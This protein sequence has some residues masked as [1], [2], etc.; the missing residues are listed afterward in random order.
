MGKTYDFGGWATKNDLKCADGRVIRRNAFKAQDGKTVPLVWRHDHLDLNNIIGHA[1]LENTDDGV[2]MYGAFNDSDLGKQAKLRVEHGDITGLS[3]WANNLVQNGPDVVHGDIKEVSLVIAPA[4]PGAYITFP[5][6]AHG[7]ESTTDA[8]IFTGEEIEVGPFISHEDD[9][10]DDEDG[11]E[12]DEKTVGDVLDTLNEE[13]MDAVVIAIGKA[14]EAATG[15]KI[16]TEDG[17]KEMK[18]NAFEDSA[19]QRTSN[20]LSH[21]DMASI[22][23]DAKRIGSLKAAVQQSMEN[24]VLSHAF[25]ENGRPYLLNDDGT[26]Q[27]YGVTD[28]DWLFP[29]YRNINNP[30]KFMP[31]DTGWVDVVMNGVHRN[32]FS[33]IK[34]QF[35]DIS[36]DEARAYGYVK[37]DKKDMEVFSLLRRTVD[38]QTI[39]KMQQLDRDDI[40]DITDFDIVAWIKQEMRMKLNEEIARAILIGDGRLTTDRHHIKEQ[41]LMPVLAD[42]ELFTIRRV[43]QRASGDTVAKMAKKFIDNNI[44]ARKKY[45]GSGNPTMFVSEDMLTECLLLEDGFGH[46]LYKSIDEL[47]TVMRASRIVTFPLLETQKHNNNQVLSISLNLDDYSLGADKGGK[48]ATFDDFD[49]DFNQYK[50]LIETRC[51]GMLT[52]PYSAIVIEMAGDPLDYDEDLVHTT[53]SSGNAEGGE[54]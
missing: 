2:F 35:A 38:P 46:K 1:L 48:I 26:H 15:K 37:G 43:I 39:Y 9:E 21:E 41:H 29:E 51:S 52:V 54:G 40:I 30:P 24:G 50:Y 25:D 49:I 18:H 20:Y 47:A 28:M 53:P 27:T 10:D 33:R 44:R 6:L 5:T 13:Q 4:N 8:I 19:R 12:D 32:P 42:E 34:T 36:M 31:R 16:S 22:F 7:E 45:K 11:E 3:I 14:V 17:G 23:E